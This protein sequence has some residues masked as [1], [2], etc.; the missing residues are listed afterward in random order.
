MPAKDQGIDKK[1]FQVIPR[2][3][4]FL[5]TEDSVLLIKGASTKRIW[6]GKYNGIGGHVE[7]NESTLQAALRELVEEAGIEDIQLSLCGNVLIDAGD[8]VG[9]EVH[10]FTGRLNSELEIIPSSEGLIEWIDLDRIEEINAVE[11]IPALIRHVQEYRT[12]GN[13]FFG[14]YRYS[15]HGKLIM[16]FDQ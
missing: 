10:I 13:L 15:E 14:T 5:F 9:V 12:S 7:K 4:V 6:A 2:V 8:D 1:R 11:D 16:T 3:L